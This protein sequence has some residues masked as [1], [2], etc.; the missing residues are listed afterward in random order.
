MATTLVASAHP[1]RFLF[2]FAPRSQLQYM[3]CYIYIY[4][5]LGIFIGYRKK[6]CL[7]T[8]APPCPQ[9]QQVGALGLGLGMRRLP[10]GGVP[11]NRHDNIFLGERRR[12]APVWRLIELCSLGE[13]PRGHEASCLAAL[14]ELVSN[15]V[16]VVWV[17]LFDKPLDVVCRRPRLSLFATSG[18]QGVSPTGGA[19]LAVVAVGRG[20]MKA[21]LAPL[22]ATFDALLGA[23]RG[24]VGWHLPVAT[25]G[26][27]PASLG[28]TKHDCLIASGALGG[29]AA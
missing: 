25:W 18:G 4:I 22:S 10:D 21:L 6:P 26:C 8:L 12:V 28:M 23:V 2:Y 27:L 16:C 5:Y 1:P 20:P 24:D 3:F 13:R 14:L 7:Y 15:R 29:D 17:G 11:I 19:C 9:P